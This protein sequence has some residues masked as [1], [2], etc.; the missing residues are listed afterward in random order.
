MA[1]AYPQRVFQAEADIAAQCHRLGSDRQL[2]APGAHQSKGFH[3]VVRDLIKSG[4]KEV[5]AGFVM[6]FVT[7]EAEILAKMKANSLNIAFEWGA[8]LKKSCL[9]FETSVRFVDV[10]VRGNAALGEC[11]TIYNE[12]KSWS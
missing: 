9:G 5:G 7:Q 1:R 3:I 10:V 2:F 11:D 12:L 4:N 8:G 6:R